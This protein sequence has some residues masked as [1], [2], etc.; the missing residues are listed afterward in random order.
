[1][2]Q[3]R[4][5]K[6]ALVTGAN[7]GIGLEV[8]RQLGAGGVTVLVGARDRALGDQAYLTSARSLSRLLLRPTATMARIDRIDRPVLVLHGDRDVL[9]PLSS[10][11]RMTEGRAGWR[12]EVAREL[13]KMRSS[14]S[15][16]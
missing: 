12:L 6:V 15:W 8:A 16:R 4:F 5:V 11:R 1:M 9:I 3:E 10:A 2:E 7:K 14:T 13:T